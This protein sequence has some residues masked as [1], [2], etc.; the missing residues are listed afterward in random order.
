[1]SLLVQDEQEL[2]NCLKANPRLAVLFYASWCPYS[3]RFLP[4]FEKQAQGKDSYRRVIVDDLDRLVD[5]YE[6]EVYPT[7]L[8][9]EQGK[10]ARRLDGVHAAGLDEGQLKKFVADCRL[11]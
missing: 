5:K 1:M 4:L 8:Y 7:V 6:I 3:H 11:P 9:F 10:V 2:N